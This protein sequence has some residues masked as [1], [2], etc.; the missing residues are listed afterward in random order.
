MKAKSKNFDGWCAFDPKGKVVHW[1]PV[2][3]IVVH[4]LVFYRAIA[5][6]KRPIEAWKRLRKEGYT[7]RKVRIIPVSERK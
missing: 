6:E 4:S 3:K 7:V 1:A 5:G 2:R